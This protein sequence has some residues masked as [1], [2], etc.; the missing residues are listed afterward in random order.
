MSTAAHPQTDGQTERAN[1]TL[2]QM[3][4][5][6]VNERK[7]DWDLRL[8]A[9][10][11]AYNNS[12]NESTG[13]TPFFLEYGIHPTCPVSL[14]NPRVTNMPNVQK[15]ADF[16]K[17]LAEDMA[18][19]KKHIAKAQNAQAYQAN[20]KRREHNIHVGDHVLLNTKNLS[21]TAYTSEKFK[22]NWCGPWEVIEEV[23]PVSYKLDLPQDTFSR[24]FPVFHV[25]L[26]K[27]YTE[28]PEHLKPSSHSSETTSA[29]STKPLWFERGQPIW[30]VEEILDRRLFKKGQYRKKNNRKTWYPP[31]YQYLVKWKGFDESENSW[32]LS[33]QFRGAAKQ[34]LVDFDTKLGAT[35]S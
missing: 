14:L 30:E 35:E 23:T 8:P 13:Q 19:A 26:L 16:A 18:V 31:V 11:F 33:T 29:Q 17:H 27:K 10:E 5:G 15:A 22:E 21:N 3:L 32:E 2:I 6:Y 24:V 25:S 9:V 12:V 7:D 28:R 34:L 20:K 4:K 1:R